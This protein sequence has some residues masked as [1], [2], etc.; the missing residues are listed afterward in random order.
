MLPSVRP[1][2]KCGSSAGPED[3][4]SVEKPL[5]GSCNLVAGMTTN[6]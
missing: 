1:I 4:G 2:N 3:M 5:I 6:L